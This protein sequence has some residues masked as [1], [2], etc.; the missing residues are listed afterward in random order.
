MRIMKKWHKIVGV[1]AF[2]AIGLCF[3]CTRSIDYT[4]GEDVFYSELPKEVQDTLIWWGEHTVF[5]VDDT[6]FV[7]L[8]DVICYNSDYSFQRSTF[9]PWIISAQYRWKGVGIFRESECSDPD[10]CNWRH[11]IHTFG[12]QCSR[13]GS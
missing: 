6:V 2:G 7:E 1:I 3:G 12:L 11:Y 10:C 4:D 8:P 5:S 13:Y 9:G